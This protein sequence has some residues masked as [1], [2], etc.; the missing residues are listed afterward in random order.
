LN[1]LSSGF[2]SLSSDSDSGHASDS[3]SFLL[4][5]DF[6]FG[7]LESVD[8]N[9]VCNFSNKFNTLEYEDESFINL[10]GV[11]DKEIDY[12]ILENLVTFKQFKYETELITDFSIGNLEN[13]NSPEF[14]EFISSNKD[15]FIFCISIPFSDIFSSPITKWQIKVENNAILQIKKPF[16]YVDNK[17]K[18]NIQNNGNKL[19]V[20]AQY[21]NKLNE[22]KLL[23]SRNEKNKLK[24]SS[25]Q[26]NNKIANKKLE[27]LNLEK[28]KLLNQINELN[29][30]NQNLEKIN[31]DLIL[32]LDSAKKKN[33]NLKDEITAF[34]SRKIVRFA[35]SIKKL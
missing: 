2:N 34:K 14:K 31:K 26:H 25:L 6:N 8:D 24:N 13:F 11:C 7:F 16:K 1:Y 20:I 22:I 10:I 5:D 15:N 23:N 4:D 3:D 19:F 32:D 9:I 27:K 30:K 21:M 28:K 29:I 18:I 12:L 35:D 17:I 33:Q